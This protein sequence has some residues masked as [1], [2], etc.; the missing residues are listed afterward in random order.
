MIYL[1]NAATTWPKPP[2]VSVTVHNAIEKLGG[3]PGRGGHQMSMRAGEALFGAR[4]KIASFFGCDQPE[5]VVFTNNATSALNFAIHGLL[6]PGDHVI[7][8]PFEH[9]AVARPCHFLSQ[10]GVEWSV[11]P[12]LPHSTGSEEEMVAAFAALVRP[13]TKLIVCNHV[14][15]V[16]GNVLPIGA[17]GH[18]ARQRGICFLVDA[19]QSAGVLPIHMEKQCIDVLAAA[20]HKG[21]YGPPGTGILLRREGIE[22]RP[23]MQGGTGSVSGRLDQPDWWPDQMESGTVNLPA[24]LGLQA[25]VDYVSRLGWERIARHEMSLR[26][27]ARRGLEKIS[28]VEVFSLPGP[29]T[30]VLSFRVK[31]EDSEETAQRLDRAGIAVRAGLHCAPLAHG[32]MGTLDTGTVRVSPGVFNNRQHIDRLLKSVKEK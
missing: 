17:I 9:N 19:S 29:C 14:S 7:T 11:A 8:S 26:E 16:F 25:G 10:Q 20:G 3:N 23:L 27:Y 31:G 12:V 22:F 1:D 15:N 28:G 6:Q 2:A 4:Q 5:Q 30:G 32:V 21:L 24:I 13:N 18:M